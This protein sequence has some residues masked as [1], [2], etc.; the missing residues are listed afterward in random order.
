MALHIGDPKRSLFKLDSMHL[1]TKL[2]PYVHTFLSEAS[3]MYEMYIYTMAERSYALEIAKIL[4]PNEVYFHSKVICQ[5]DCTQRYQKGL[6]V[7]LGAEN[8]VVILDDTEAVSQ[9]FLKLVYTENVVSHTL[10]SVMIL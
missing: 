3:N 9:W 10:D 2:R 4:D 5:S 8:T 7:V 6:D 1:L